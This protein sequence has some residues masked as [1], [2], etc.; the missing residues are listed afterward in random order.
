M[1]YESEV[2]IFLLLNFC[3]HRYNS[4]LWIVCIDDIAVYFSQ[5]SDEFLFVSAGGIWLQ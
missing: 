1:L 3:A 5:I 2:Q 4:H